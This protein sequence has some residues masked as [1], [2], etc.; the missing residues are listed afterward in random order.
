MK[1]IHNLNELRVQVSEWKRASHT[2]ALVPTMG[3]LHAG[4]LSLIE[5]AKQSADKILVS[6]F[7]N[8]IQFGKG[9]DY[10]HYPSTLE[11]DSLKLKKLNLDLLFSPD[12]K[13]LYPGGTDDDTRVSVPD[14]SDILCGAYRPGHFSGVATV[15]SKLFINIQPDLA[16]FG[17]KDYQQ[18]LIIKRMTEDL[19]IPVKIE[20]VSI[21]REEDGLAMSS[22]NSYLTEQERSNAPLIYQ[23][24]MK[25]GEQLKA[26]ITDIDAIES[27]AIS[28]LEK[29]GFK[30]EYFSVRRVHDLKDPTVND[31][32]YIILAAAWIGKTRLIDNIKVSK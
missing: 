29:S 12:L 11:E 25:A 5:K 4:H 27:S 7:V 10:A 19:C 6:V 14:L 3:N 32:N 15:V 31:K 13:Q 23:T 8:P 2:I 16:F 21:M 30:P 22:R 24:L 18:L 1:I 9:E 26:S 17:E 20:G 28:D